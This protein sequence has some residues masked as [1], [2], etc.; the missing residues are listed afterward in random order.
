MKDK[1]EYLALGELAIFLVAWAIGLVVV[2]DHYRG[3]SDPSGRGEIA[4]TS[5]SEET[6][7][8]LEK[9]FSQ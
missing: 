2:I 7:G 8:Q 3:N 1:R 6:D 9:V 5:P 4:A